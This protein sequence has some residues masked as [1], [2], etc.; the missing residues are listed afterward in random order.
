MTI[1]KSAIVA[2]G[3]AI[4]CCAVLPA[5]ASAQAA[6]VPPLPRNNVR[7]GALAARRPGNFVQSG[8]ST[9]SQRISVAITDFGGVTYSDTEPQSFRDQV[10]PQL[11]DVF[12]GIVDQLAT[13]IETLIRGGTI[14][15]T[16][17]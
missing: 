15:T 1:R 12:L 4:A 14:P 10:L 7:G 5:S 16:G 3:I 9:T 13:I 6:N 11:V 2:F 8:I 17:T